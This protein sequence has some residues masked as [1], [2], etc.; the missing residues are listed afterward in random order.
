[1]Q[2]NNFNK[3]FYLWSVV[4]FSL[5]LYACGGKKQS[6]VVTPPADQKTAAV[7]CEL[8]TGNQTFMSA[9]YGLAQSKGD[10]IFINKL[11]IEQ[12]MNS[13]KLEA[14]PEMEKTRSEL[15]D[16][17]DHAPKND[18]PLYTIEFT[19]PAITLRDR[20]SLGIQ[21]YMEKCRQ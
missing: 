4:L 11:S 19:Q 17:L 8:W 14:D 9:S 16:L 7:N 12:L 3:V 21:L 2:I 5:I 10:K 20:L 6:D 13:L 15:I 18:D 1:M